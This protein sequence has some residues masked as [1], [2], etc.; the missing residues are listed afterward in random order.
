MKH[1]GSRL[2]RA[3]YRISG[4]RVWL[5]GPEIPTM[6]L[7]TTGRKTGKARTVPLNYVRDGDKLVA[8]CENFGLEKASSWPMNAL[9][10]PD[11]T[12]QIGTSVKDWRAR[13][14]TDE[15]VARNMPLLVNLWPAHDTYR[16]RS[17]RRY[18][19]VFEPVPRAAPGESEPCSG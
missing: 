9:A 8:S 13:L 4:G 11:V 2:D 18:V 10:H 15:E 17:G 19:F 12:V 7:T 14:A 6:L 1:A 5:S 16:E 3:L